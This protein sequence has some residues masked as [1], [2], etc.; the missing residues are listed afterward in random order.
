MFPFIGGQYAL[1]LEQQ[2]EQ[3][4]SGKRGGITAN[5][6]EM[7]ASGLSDDQIKAV[8]DYFAG[9]QPKISGVSGSSGGATYHGPEPV[10]HPHFGA[11]PNPKPGKVDIVKGANA[12]PNGEAQ[13]TQTNANEGGGAGGENRQHASGAN[14][15]AR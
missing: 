14:D 15:A 10:A 7:I 2:L 11:A 12:S 1:Y 13:N 5:V 8:A 9:L 4:K 3:F 6:M